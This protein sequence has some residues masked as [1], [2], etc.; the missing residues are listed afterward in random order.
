MLMADMELRVA[1]FA[2]CWDVV[3]PAVVFLPTYARYGLFVVVIALDQPV[4]QV[5]VLAVPL[6]LVRL[7]ISTA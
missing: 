1:V 6:D 4:F 5:I 3:L 7:M 2:V